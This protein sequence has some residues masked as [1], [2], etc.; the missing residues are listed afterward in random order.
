MLDC[1]LGLARLVQDNPQTVVRL[2]VFGPDP[3]GLLV[4]GNRLRHLAQLN[5]GDPQVVV[6]LGVIR[7]DP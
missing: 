4:P 2:D 5:Q 3:Q 1:L 6:R 7:L